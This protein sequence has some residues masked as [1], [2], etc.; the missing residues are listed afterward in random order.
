[1]PV[2][3]HPN[4][5]APVPSPC[6]ACLNCSL[7]SPPLLAHLQDTGGR[8]AVKQVFIRTGG[9]GSWQ[10][11]SNSWGAAWEA[12]STPPAPLDLKVVCDDGEEVRR[13]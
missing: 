8:A 9:S 5:C 12:S 13:A 2:Q 1:M 11:M 4:F 6:V 7:P 10:A 3:L